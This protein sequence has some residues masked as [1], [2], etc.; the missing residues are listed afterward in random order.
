M[1]QPKEVK[2][3]EPVYADA[4]KSA[5]HDDEETDA[6]VDKL[7]EEEAAAS[8]PQGHLWLGALRHSVK[9]EMIK[10]RPASWA[11]GGKVDYIE[12]HTVADILDRELGGCWNYNISEI[13]VN[14]R[15]ATCRA[16]LSIRLGDGDDYMFV[17]RDGVGVGVAR[18]D[19]PD[20]YDNAI[21][22]AASDALKR[23]AVMFGVGRDLYI[24]EPQT[25]QDEDPFYRDNTDS[26]GPR[27]VTY[28][29]QERST[30]ARDFAVRNPAD[31]ISE[32]Q[33]GLL[34]VLAR[35]AGCDIDSE[36]AAKYDKDVIDLNK[37]EASEFI[38]YMKEMAGE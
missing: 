8:D 36:C 37:G 38:S 17:S 18:G 29:R 27:V 3:K 6:L 28:G 12:W 4:K 26:K 10:Q 19:S 2:T 13:E 21:K 32:K 5:F 9:P 11:P 7:T 35:K 25:T 22:T 24:D 33:V 1:A 16:T 14:S 20:A 15:V 34:R 23:C 31:P 30:G